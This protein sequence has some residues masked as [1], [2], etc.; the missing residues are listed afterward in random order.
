MRKRGRK[1]RKTFF[2]SFSA[3]S[4]NTAAGAQTLENHA[5]LQQ[6]RVIYISRIL[7]GNA[8]FVHFRTRVKSQMILEIN[9]LLLNG[10]TQQAY[11]LHKHKFIIFPSQR[12]SIIVLFRIPSLSLFIRELSRHVVSC[13]RLTHRVTHSHTQSFESTYSHVLH[14]SLNIDLKRN[15][16]FPAIAA[17]QSQEFTNLI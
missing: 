9:L 4:K 10:I 5:L 12:Y 8:T 6:I 1:R 17:K 7:K 14:L 11:F 16:Y 3:C 2:F 13:K 15:L